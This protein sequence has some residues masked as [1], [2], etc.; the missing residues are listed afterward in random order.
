MCEFYLNCDSNSKKTFMKTEYQVF[1]VAKK[2]RNVLGT[3]WRGYIF[4]GLLIFWRYILK[5]L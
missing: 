2:L 4:K 5:Y 3:D 1:E